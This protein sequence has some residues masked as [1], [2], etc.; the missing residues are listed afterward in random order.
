[1]SQ[2]TGTVGTLK[3]VCMYVYIYILYMASY[4]VL[5]YPQM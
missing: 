4:L 3:N 1:M 5:I 2:N